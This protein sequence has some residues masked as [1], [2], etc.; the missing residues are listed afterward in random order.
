MYKTE[1]FYYVERKPK[2]SKEEDAKE[3]E[4][5]G[6]EEDMNVDQEY[7]LKEEQMMLIKKEKIEGKLKVKSKTYRIFHIYWLMQKQIEYYNKNKAE[8][9][10]KIENKFTREF[11]LLPNKQNFT[12][13]NLHLTNTALFGTKNLVEMFG[14]KGI[15][16]ELY[17]ETIW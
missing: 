4:T 8:Y 14:C 16:S 6:I 1:C 7:G 12:V 3:K 5:E 11:S 15:K 9:N 2:K 17:L 10:I 13:S